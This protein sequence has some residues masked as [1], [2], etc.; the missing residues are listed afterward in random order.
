MVAFDKQTAE[1]VGSRVGCAATT[2]VDDRGENGREFKEQRNM[3]GG[4]CG[5][6]GVPGMG[7]GSW[8]GRV[9]GKLE[10]FCHG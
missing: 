1:E 8:R 10:D 2:G 9:G 3:K 4:G 6:L 7:R 5:M